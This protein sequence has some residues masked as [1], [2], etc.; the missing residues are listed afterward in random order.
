[1]FLIEK[2]IRYKQGKYVTHIQSTV[3]N[4]HRHIALAKVLPFYKPLG[5]CLVTR[6]NRYESKHIFAYLYSNAYRELSSFRF[7]EARQLR[8]E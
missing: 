5:V 3:T 4:L 2:K 1:M 8:V 6:T 7:L